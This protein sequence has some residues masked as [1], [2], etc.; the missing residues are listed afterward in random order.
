MV[1]NMLNN[2]IPLCIFLEENLCTGM[3]LDK[4]VSLGQLLTRPVGKSGSAYNLRLL[5]CSTILSL[6]CWSDGKRT[7][8]SSKQ[9]TKFEI[10]SLFN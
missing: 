7:L 9:E 5:R 2:E 3:P 4:L 6:H 10:V 8:L 1:V